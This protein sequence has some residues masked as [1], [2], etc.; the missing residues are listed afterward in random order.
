MVPIKIPIF[1]VDLV[2]EQ[3]HVTKASVIIPFGVDVTTGEYCILFGD[4]WS[5]CDFCEP[6]AE[7][8]RTGDFDACGHCLICQR[9]YRSKASREAGH[10]LAMQQVDILYSVEAAREYSIPVTGSP[11]AAKIMG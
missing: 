7:Y 11:L 4:A 3:G 2:C 6:C 1:Q 5:F 8:E 9:G 10:I